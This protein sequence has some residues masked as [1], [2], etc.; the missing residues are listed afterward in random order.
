VVESMKMQMKLT[1]PQAAVVEVVHDLPGQDVGQGDRLVT[2][3]P[4][5]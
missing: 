4:S 3:R 2:L 5:K 1:A